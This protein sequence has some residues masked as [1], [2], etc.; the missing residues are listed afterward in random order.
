M[1]LLISNNVMRLIMPGIC[2]SWW[3]RLTKSPIGY[4]LARGAF[5]SVI[6]TVVA[7]GVGLVS[8]ILI[9][10][11]LGKGSFGEY[12]MIQST[13]AMFS[14]LAG[15]GMGLTAA[16][17][18]AEY[19]VQAPEQA[20][21]I[22][23]LS[24]LAAWAGGAL[25]AMALALGAPY[26]AAQTLAAPQ[27]TLLL[28]LSAPL[29]LL[30]S[31][32]GAQVGALNGFEAFQRI[33]RLNM[34]TG[35]AALPLSLVGV[36]G[37]GLPGAVGALVVGAGLRVLLTNSAL[38]AEMARA[39]VMSS[40]RGCWSE[41]SVMWRFSLPAILSGLVMAPALWG[42]NV[43]LVNRP[44]G[45]DQM[46]TWGA[47][48][49]WRNVV[50]FLPNIVMQAV[51]PI[52][53]S[54]TKEDASSAG[55]FQRTLA[56]T[57]SMMVLVS[58]PVCAGLMFYSDWLMRLYWRAAHFESAALIGCLLASLV[59]CLGAATGPALQARSRMWLG[60]AFNV[61]WGV[62]Y[63]G[64]VALF[65][66]R[67]GATA[68]AFGQALAYILLTVWGFFYMRAD[69][70]P[71]MFRRVLLGLVFACVLGGVCLRLSPEWRTWLGA[72]AA[73]LAGLVAALVLVD[74]SLTRVLLGGWRLSP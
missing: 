74:K 59:Q 40:W 30:D 35:L 33:A 19:R 56:L 5:W 54:S 39:N 64:V 71:G 1:Q 7:R 36:I 29:L 46:A 8:S 42:A 50:L 51:L 22:I 55:S 67:L 52:L 70:P 12:G 44:G 32:N 63:I 43:M 68:L 4:R 69:L 21:R 58:F 34:I 13:V 14:T 47:A 65:V 9:A 15:V 48:N 73:A 16:K 38:R 37:W 18:V 31:V 53:A 11:L 57:Q 28:V 45:Y 20:G 24:T 27:L 25:M 26:L 3:R 2:R 61:S 23:R 62:T 60:L 10:R 66:D 41:R 49:Q 17:H 6:G 72:P